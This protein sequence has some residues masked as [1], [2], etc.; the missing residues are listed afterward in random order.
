MKPHLQKVVIPDIKF[1]LKQDQPQTNNETE[2]INI[3]KLI[4][5]TESL[6]LQQI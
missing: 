5:P 1:I 6:Q 3:T 2:G 4:G